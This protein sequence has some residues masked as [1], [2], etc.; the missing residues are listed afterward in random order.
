MPEKQKAGTQH[1]KSTTQ[2]KTKG[3]SASDK[4]E[5]SNILKEPPDKRDP[6][7]GTDAIAVARQGIDNALAV[8]AQQVEADVRLKSDPRYEND[9]RIQQAAAGGAL[10]LLPTIPALGVPPQLVVIVDKDDAPPSGEAQPATVEEQVER[11]KK[12]L[13]EAEKRKAEV[14]KKQQ[15]LTDR[16]TKQVTESTKPIADATSKTFDE[17][18]DDKDKPKPTPAR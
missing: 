12:R 13:D 3:P 7:T 6:N 2:L 4:L 17:K 1:P 15:E 18:S 14:A 11:D 9:V 16:V 5:D 8:V 10:A